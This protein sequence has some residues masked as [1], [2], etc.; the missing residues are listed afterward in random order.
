[1]HGKNAT[2]AQVVLRHC[3]WQPCATG[4]LVSGISDTPDCDCG[5]SGLA[6]RSWSCRDLAGQCMRQGH[7]HHTTSGR[8][9]GKSRSGRGNFATE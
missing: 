1:L 3:H 5:W 4:N 9:A 2:L 8:A 7:R 6:C